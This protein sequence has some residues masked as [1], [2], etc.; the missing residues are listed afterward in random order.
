[1][2]NFHQKV[3]MFFG[4]ILGI[5]KIVV[6]SYYSTPFTKHL[7]LIHGFKGLVTFGIS[8]YKITKAFFTLVTRCIFTHAYSLYNSFIIFPIKCQTYYFTVFCI[9]CPYTHTKCHKHNTL[10][11]SIATSVATTSI[12]IIT[13]NDLVSFDLRP[14]LLSFPVRMYDWLI[15]SMVIIGFMTNTITC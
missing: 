9:Y 2:E 8:T 6:L 13:I 4:C 12:A 1:M 14:I 11:V 3:S 7:I 5:Y 10:N 15:V